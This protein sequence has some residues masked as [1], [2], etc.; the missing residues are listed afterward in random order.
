[1][2]TAEAQLL[3]VG[4]DPNIRSASTG[5]SPLEAVLMNEAGAKD[6]ELA[7]RLVRALVRAGVDVNEV[8]SK[9]STALHAACYYGACGEV[10]QALLD[11]GADALAPCA[12]FH[13]YT[14][15]Q[16]AS[17][18][19]SPGALRVMIEQPGCGGLNALGASPERCAVNVS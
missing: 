5:E 7:P 9:G 19:G 4:A 3:E 14:P 15:I 17:I 8:G 13:F 6:A 18:G 2:Y 11:A 10:V 1:M 16:L 12:G